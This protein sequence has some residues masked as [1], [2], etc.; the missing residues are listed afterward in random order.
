LEESS[1]S[2]TLTIKAFENS[3]LCKE[4][5]GVVTKD[6]IVSQMGMPTSESDRLVLDNTKCIDKGNIIAE[7]KILPKNAKRRKL[8]QDILE[9]SKSSDSPLNM[10]YNLKTI[11]EDT[12][13]L[14][15]ARKLTVKAESVDDEKWT[16]QLS[17]L[18][19]IPSPSDIEMLKTPPNLAEEEEKLLK[20]IR[21]SSID[22]YPDDEVGKL[23]NDI[24]SLQKTVEKQIHSM[25]K[26]AED[27]TSMFIQMFV[28][29]MGCMII[30]LVIFYQLVKYDN[31][32]DSKNNT[33]PI[34]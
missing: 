23:S 14:R 34:K 18:K 5:D 15:R 4:V 33:M 30:L 13:A 16:F 19:I 1:I 20:I 21:I 29:A 9:F 27:M 8:R 31:Y 6:V 25:N 12:N 7:V 22:G 10:F 2:F 11:S 17:N 24:Y 32:P 3:E 28:I 26:T